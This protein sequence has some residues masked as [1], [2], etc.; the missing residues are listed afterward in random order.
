[1]HAYPECGWRDAALA[2]SSRC[3]AWYYKGDLDRAIADCNEAIR[4]DPKY[5]SNYQNRGY[6][7]FLTGNFTA[8]AVDLLRANDLADND[9]AMLWRYLA[10]RHLK[11][12]GTPPPNWAPMR[13]A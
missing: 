9:Y 4:L 7:Y 12:G 8:A 6:S 2:Y 3:V 5:A 11:Q 10:R 13:R 1:M